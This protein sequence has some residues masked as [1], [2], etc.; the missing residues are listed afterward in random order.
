M[1][2]PELVMKFLTVLGAPLNLVWKGNSAHRGGGDSV[3]Q[4]TPRTGIFRVLVSM[5][6]NSMY[7]SKQKKERLIRVI[8]RLCV[9]S[10]CVRNLGVLHRPLTLILLQKYRDTNG[11]RIVIQIG[12]VCTTFCQEEGILLQKHRDRNRGVSRCFSKVSESG[13]DVTLLIIWVI[14]RIVRSV[15]V[16]AKWAG[17]GAQKETPSAPQPMSSVC[18]RFPIIS[19]EISSREK[20]LRGPVTEEGGRAFPERTIGER[21]TLGISGNSLPLLVLT[22]QG[23]APVKTS[24]GNTF[25]T[26]YQR[27]PPK[28]YQYWC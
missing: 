6:K 3:N 18:Q 17:L 9:Q 24:T 10:P 2:R 15:S 8:P 5:L 21:T 19:S 14:R 16:R 26:K 11:R 27:I 25:P 23:A 4:Q 28:C 13:V 1:E 12:G 7:L 20:A 22:R